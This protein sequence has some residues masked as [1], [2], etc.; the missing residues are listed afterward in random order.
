MESLSV[1]IEKLK[2][3]WSDLR[4][5]AYRQHYRH[6]R[7]ILAMIDAIETFKKASV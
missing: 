7:E 5:E 2:E 6:D 1:T 4:I 3:I